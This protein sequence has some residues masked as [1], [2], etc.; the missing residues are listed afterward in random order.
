MR[1]VRANT[2]SGPIQQA[3]A[4]VVLMGYEGI[5]ESAGLA[6]WGRKTSLARETY[7]KAHKSQA[8]SSSSL[9]S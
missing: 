7:F 3:R 6:A 8:L 5:E 4:F 9:V 2:R 1:L